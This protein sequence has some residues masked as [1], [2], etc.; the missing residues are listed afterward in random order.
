MKRSEA[1]A[2]RAC[3]R[4]CDCKECVEKTVALDMLERAMQIVNWVARA[5]CEYSESP[6]CECRPCQARELLREWEAASSG[7]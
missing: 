5:P 7:R 4:A 2:A 3:S 6:N 1:A